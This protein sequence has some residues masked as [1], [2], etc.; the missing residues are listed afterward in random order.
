MSDI[1]TVWDAA[2]ARGDYRVAG[3]S[4]ESGHDIQTAVLISL[5]TD[6]Q[7]L[8]DDD[9]PDAPPSGPADRRGWW[10]D[11]DQ[12]KIGSRLWLLDRAKGPMDTAKRAE[13]YAQEAVKWMVDTGA[14]AK[15]D[16]SAQWK[17]PNQLWLAVTAYRKDGGTV[18]LTDIQLW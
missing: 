9:I 14:V 13:A 15:F 7:A 5:F 10:G 11:S 1:R 8:P 16:I 2:N 3:G 6:R 18:A 12:S 4:L 17:A